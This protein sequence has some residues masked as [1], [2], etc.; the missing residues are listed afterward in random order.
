MLFLLIPQIAQIL[1]AGLML[2]IFIGY[3]VKWLSTPPGSILTKENMFEVIEVVPKDGYYLVTLETV[4]KDN[5]LFRTTHLY[6]VGDLVKIRYGSN[7][8]GKS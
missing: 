2:G 6:G 8:V 7:Q 4:E 3:F 5:I 1:I